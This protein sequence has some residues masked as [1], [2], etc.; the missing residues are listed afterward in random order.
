MSTE[1]DSNR[2]TICSTLI[3]I[4]DDLLFKEFFVVTDGDDGLPLPFGRSLTAHDTKGIKEQM[5]FPDYVRSYSKNSQYTGQNISYRL[6]VGDYSSAK[7]FSD[8]VSTD[9][10]S[11]IKR[12][13]VIRADVDNLGNAFVNGFTETGGG[14]YETLSR[15]STFSRMLSEFFKLR[16]NNILKKGVFNIADSTE[17]ESRN[18][19]IVYS[20]G[21][22][23]FVVGKWDDI[24]GFA[25]DLHNCLDRYSER[26]LTLSAGIGIFDEKYPI[27]MMA[28]SVGKLE[29]YAKAYR[30]KDGSITKNAVALFDKD[31]VYAWDVFIEKVVDEKLNAVK[32]LVKNTQHET[33]M[34]YKMLELIRGSNDKLNVAR[35]AYLLARL[36]PRDDAPE[37]TKVEYA[38]L[39][40]KLFRWI[41]STEDRNQLITAIYIFVYCNRGCNRET[42]E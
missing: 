7:Q 12:L 41:K 8:L 36:R 2:C 11:G 40:E 24:I 13:G 17:R 16:V 14:K 28:E 15:T 42:E 27:Y 1:P 18:A 31:N 26:T 4:S 9:I 38:A 22:D 33:A 29:D 34:L 25:V 6:W 30:N 19:A 23:L 39:S 20:G 3:D 37:S 5:G 10:D 32:A 21:D 35:Y